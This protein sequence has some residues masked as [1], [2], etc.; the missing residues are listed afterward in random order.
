MI[1]IFSFLIVAML[2][3]FFAALAIAGLLI[4]AILIAAP[5]ALVYRFFTK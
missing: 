1:E 5:F 2:F 4:V 3:L